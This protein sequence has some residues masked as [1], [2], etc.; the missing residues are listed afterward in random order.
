MQKIKWERNEAAGAEHPRG[1][2]P[3]SACKCAAQMRRRRR[4]CDQKTR[5]KGPASE[6]EGVYC[7]QHRRALMNIHEAF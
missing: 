5:R 4:H 6:G 1:Q 2:E 3:L 7:Y